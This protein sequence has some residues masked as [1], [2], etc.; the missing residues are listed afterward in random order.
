ME[1]GFM[2]VLPFRDLSQC[3]ATRKFVAIVARRLAKDSSKGPME[4]GERLETDIVSDLTDPQ[5]V[6]LMTCLFSQTTSVFQCGHP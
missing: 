3:S 1:R 6:A 4:L 5:F 2:A